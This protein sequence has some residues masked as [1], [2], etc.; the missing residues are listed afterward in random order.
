M[1]CSTQLSLHSIVAVSK[2]KV[3]PVTVAISV[4]RLADTDVI[5]LGFVTAL[6]DRIRH[7]FLNELALPCLRDGL[8][9]NFHTFYL[10]IYTAKTRSAA[11]KRSSFVVISLFTDNCEN[12]SSQSPQPMRSKHRIGDFSRPRQLT[13][14]KNQRYEIFSQHT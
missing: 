14:G 5:S 11:C 4:T 13:T 6:T 1:L 9:L 10:F 3:K 12:E 7:V 2:L 8:M